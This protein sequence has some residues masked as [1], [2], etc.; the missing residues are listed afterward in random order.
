MLLGTVR[1]WTT[2]LSLNGSE[3]ANTT[4]ICKVP[5]SDL[6]INFV[7]LTGVDFGGK[8]PV[9][10]S[11]WN[12]VKPGRRRQRKRRDHQ[13]GVHYA[14]V[15]NERTRIDNNAGTGTIALNFGRKGASNYNKDKSDDD[16]N[17]DAGNRKR[18]R[19]EEGSRLGYV[20]L[21]GDR[22]MLHVISWFCWFSRRAQDFE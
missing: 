3:Q 22:I 21:G 1:R 15:F 8:C 4:C 6:S 20:T 12:Q 19:I 5:Q 10:M 16:D 17:S 13:G 7:S 14:I 2:R 11:L 18:R 9:I